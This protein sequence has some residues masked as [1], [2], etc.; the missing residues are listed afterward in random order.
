MIRVYLVGAQ[1]VGFGQQLI[2]PLM[3]APPGTDRP[4]CRNPA[5]A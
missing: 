5:R 1:V 3:P 4:L 2:R